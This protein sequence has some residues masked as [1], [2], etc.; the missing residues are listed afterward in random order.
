MP[1]QPGG[2]SRCHPTLGPKPNTIENLTE[3]DYKNV[4]CLLCH[5]PDYKRTVAKVGEKD[6]GSPILGFVPAEGVDILTVAQNVSNP[7]S[8]M[9]LRCHARL[10]Y[11]GSGRMLIRTIVDEEHNPG[12]ECVMCHNPH[13]PGFN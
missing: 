11:K 2:C 1:A 12:M 4:D 5:G 7:D 3:D 8:Q 13:K 6:D 9:C 10:P